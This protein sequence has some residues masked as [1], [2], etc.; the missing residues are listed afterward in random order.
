MILRR[1]TKHVQDQNWT[2]IAIDF[3]IVVVG[4]FVGLQVSNWNAA[5]LHDRSERV[6]IE[7]IREDIA[8]NQDDL[9]LRLSY[10]RQT[11]S[12]ALATLAALDKPS[13]SLGVPFLVDVYQ[14]SQIIPRG[15]G[16]DT[17]DEIISVGANSA[18]SNLAVRK[19]IANYYSSVWA[20]ISIL[21]ETTSYRET[22][23]RTMPYGAQVA[24]RAACGDIIETRESGEPVISLPESCSVDLPPEAVSS[25]VAAIVER[26]LRDDLVRR[27]V[28]LDAKISFAHLIIDRAQLLDDYLAEASG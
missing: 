1:I 25:A 19:R 5:R 26:D 2:A 8:A 12:H 7:R 10:F 6:Y 23:R 20:V 22:V 14:A 21:E 18:I 9:R 15:F 27:L 13:D 24:I 17:Y 11:R 16:R 3:V 28:D 4:V